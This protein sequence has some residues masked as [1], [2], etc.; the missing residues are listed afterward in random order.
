[1]RLGHTPMVTQIRRTGPRRI[2]C[3]SAN[4]DSTAS[5]ACASLAGEQSGSSRSHE[6]RAS[7][8]IEAWLTPGMDERI[9]YPLRQVTVGP[10]PGKIKKPR[11]EH[12]PVTAI[13]E[14]PR[15]AA[16]I[17]P[18]PP[19]K[20]GASHFREKKYPHPP[21]GA[22]GL[23]RKRKYPTPPLD[24]ACDPIPNSLNGAVGEIGG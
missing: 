8:Q 22:S 21:I 18:P 4:Q 5:L 9:E 19:E 10:K 2:N 24:A 17:N 15:K 12:T 7:E 16:I 20:G 11:V 23:G 1:M 6:A 14:P 13:T 3:R